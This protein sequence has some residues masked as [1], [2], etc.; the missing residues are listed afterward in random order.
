MLKG[1]GSPQELC[2]SGRVVHVMGERVFK[3]TLQF[4]R[5]VH[6]MGERAFKGTL[7]F[8]EGSTCYRGEGHQRNF[9]VLE[10]ST[11][12]RGEGLHRNLQF[13]RVVHV[14]GSRSPKELCFF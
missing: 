5:V 10:G 14:I 1:R 4:W 12:Y 6:V 7:Q 8:Q 11:C 13:W 9:A 2:S 3:G